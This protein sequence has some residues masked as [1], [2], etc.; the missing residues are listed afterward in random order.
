M[1]A[2]AVA[3]S[4]T[5]TQTWAMSPGTLCEGEIAPGAPSNGELAQVVARAETALADARLSGDVA[6]AV[7]ASLDV[8][9]PG[10][11]AERAAYCAVAGEAMRLAPSG[12]AADAQRYLL[13]A[14]T[15]AEQA[16][17][18]PIAA[19]AAYRL[20]LA[21][22][23]STATGDGRGARS[24]VRTAAVAPAVDTTSLEAAGPC[25]DLVTRGLTRTGA[26]LSRTA[27]GCSVAR[28]RSG[29][30]PDQAALAGLKLARVALADIKARPLAAR[31][32]RNEAR[33]AAL[34]AMV[35]AERIADPY[36]RAELLGRS[37]EVGLDAGLEDTAALSAAIAAMQAAVPDDPASQAFAA[38]LV[39]RIAL[40]AGDR[41]AASA[42]LQRAVFL[43]SQ[44]PQPLRLSD[45]MLL[46]AQAEPERRDAHLMQA[47]TALESVRPI[48]PMVDPLTEESN[49]TLRMQPVFEA[50]VDVQLAST[51]DDPV[52][53]AMAQGIIEAYRQA[54][55]QSAFGPNCVPPSDPVRPADLREGEILLYPVL[56]ADRVELIYAVRD[57]EGPPRFSR[58]PADRSM[59]RARVTALVN[60]ASYSAGYGGDSAWRDPS[61]QLYDLLIKP[62]EGHL[63]PG[64]TL[65][66][67]PDGALRALPFA[68]L[69]DAKQT[70]LIQKT[71]LSVAPALSYSQPGVDRGE[72]ELAV[73]AAS[74]EKEVV[75][76]AGTFAKLEATGEEARVAYAEGQG[77]GQ[78]LTDFNK[79]E[80]SQALSRGR[81]DVLH[82]A[83]HAAFNGRSD[84]SFIVANDEAIPMS[85]LREMIGGNRARGDEIDLLILSACETAVGDDQATMG[86][87]GAAVQAG[88]VSAIASLWEVS[89]AGTVELMR[90]FYSA[91]RDGQSKAEA[92]RS[93]QIAMIEQGGDDADPNVWAAFTLLGG[94]R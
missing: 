43:E 55:L 59:N 10:S 45:W 88:A 44:R 34:G 33:E 38:A 61:R 40:G 68:L 57:G 35:D 92:L 56:L 65:V 54:E 62:I 1:A 63:S 58:L 23:T 8:A 87:A 36:L 90:G 2:L 51:S 20:G 41:G 69:T 91:Y 39:G 49:F 42:A 79:A 24:A 77:R 66:I 26:Q 37:A 29:G 71:R 47:Y 11:L 86:L 80:L 13:R 81:V 48:L 32:L 64:S 16:D 53:I 84:R 17:D 50:A 73:V 85:E 67:V 15:L 31:G 72:R 60:E 75:L 21:A 7:L 25:R 19:L 46:L 94:W 28:G 27:L 52:R 12:N 4:L 78:L 70:F 82:L 30:V 74:L 83:T 76:P 5:A 93:A 9:G 14:V 22:T 6:E 89:D 3:G 18:A